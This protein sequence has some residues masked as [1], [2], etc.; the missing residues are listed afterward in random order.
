MDWNQP[1]LA[2]LRHERAWVEIDPTAVTRNTRTIGRLL[3][4]HTKLM[5]VVKSDGY[6][7]GLVDVAQA[8]A[9]GG[10]TWL[11]VAS[12]AEGVSL[13]LAGVGLPIL[14]LGAVHGKEEVCT[15]ARWGLRP[16]ICDPD[17]AA[18]VA[19]SL[20]TQDRPLPVHLKLDTGMTRLGFPWK[21][22]EEF[23]VTV[24]RFSVLAVEGVFSHL[25][26]AD[27]PDSA[28][29]TTQRECFS[30]A[31]TGIRQRGSPGVLAHLA[32]SVATLYAPQTYFDMVRVGLAIYGLHPCPART[33]IN[34]E[35]VMQ[36]RARISQTKAVPGGTGV[37]YSHQ[38]VTDGPRRL[39]VV[40]IG[41]ADGV[42]RSLSGRMAVLAHGKRLPQVGAIMTNQL[43][44]D[45]SDQ[46]NLR[47]GD[48]VTILGQDGGER[49]AAEE[50]VGAL[51][52]VLQ[53]K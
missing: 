2:S 41:Y 15:L 6:G 50:W 11:G 18:E 36:I 34:L 48:V 29:L 35:P 52:T 3:P 23:F 44:I 9:R 25:A 49:I 38:F 45:A 10:A 27:Q 1:E 21:Q 22:T 8:A 37:G 24:R 19:S 53:R 47:P 20:R 13:R 32:N 12:V 14:I 28:L 17:H 40:S 42:P 30:S 39:A 5:A 51:N 31:V 26:T 46:P 16:T 33:G 7:H 4:A 43:I